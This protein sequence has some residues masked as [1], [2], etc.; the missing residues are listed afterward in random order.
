MKERRKS[1]I[2]NK[3]ELHYNFVRVP[4]YS[5]EITS[6]YFKTML[7]SVSSYCYETL[8]TVLIYR[9]NYYSILK[10]NRK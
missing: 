8:Q 2:R 3:Y 7:K 9:H 1:K 5:I 6:V 10:L 4:F